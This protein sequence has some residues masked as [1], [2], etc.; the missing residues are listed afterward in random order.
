M[1]S[2]RSYAAARQRLSGHGAAGGVLQSIEIVISLIKMIR[3]ALLNDMDS[4]LSIVKDIVIDM[5]KNGNDQWTEAYP[6]FEDFYA[7][8]SSEE[9]FVDQDD[10]G[11]IMS[12]VCLNTTEPPEYETVF[13]QS[14]QKALVIHRL[15]VNPGFQ[16]RGLAKK[17]I[18]FA[19][20]RAKEMDL[21]FL[22]SD[23]CVQNPAMNSLF[24]KL[25][26]RNVGKIHFS[27]CKYEFNCYEKSF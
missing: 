10:S 4:I 15:A 8:I 20:Q 2:N 6:V 18:M 17:I 25:Q 27:D 5:K 24:E 7:D 11:N 19:E 22:R 23:T 1:I 14:D 21:N 3:K 26:Y 16:G 9:F 13:R 12:F